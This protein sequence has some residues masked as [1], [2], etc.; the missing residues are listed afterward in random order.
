MQGPR[1]F[2]TSSYLI[3]TITQ[4]F[5]VGRG[6]PRGRLA[7]SGDSLGCHGW[8]GEADA[9]GMSG[10]SQV[11]PRVLPTT[12]Q[13]TGQPHNGQVTCPICRPLRPGNPELMPGGSGLT[14]SLL[15]FRVKS[16]APEA[17]ELGILTQVVAS[18]AM[19]GTVTP[20]ASL[21]Q[22]RRGQPLDRVSRN[23]TGTGFCGGKI[24]V[25]CGVAGGGWTVRGQGPATG[26]GVGR[27]VG[28]TWGPR[29]LVRAA[30]ST[31]TR[32]RSANMCV[33][34]ATSIQPR[35]DRISQAGKD[36]CSGERPGRTLSSDKPVDTTV[37]TGPFVRSAL[38]PRGW[39]RGGR[40]T[41]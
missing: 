8:W 4:W 21:S 33:N 36:V 22:P 23:V 15:R 41:I 31:L 9:T 14:R 27:L 12:P 26:H 17:P 16:A 2:C 38:S 18:A 10:M 40:G 20:T 34:A 28:W 32:S 25:A 7:M 39:R 6:H 37:P 1:A 30:F 24:T 11:W 13:G 29:L 5:S 3:L 35:R 19:P